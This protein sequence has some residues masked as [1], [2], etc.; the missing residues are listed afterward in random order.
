ML[1][2]RTRCEDRTPLP[3][4]PTEAARL[5]LHP[6]VAGAVPWVARTLEACVRPGARGCSPR[7]VQACGGVRTI[8]SLEFGRCVD[9]GMSFSSGVSIEML[10]AVLASLSSCRD[11][12][13]TRN[14]ETVDEFR[15]LCRLPALGESCV[16][17]RN[18]YPASRT[19]VNTEHYRSS[20]ESER[21]LLCAQ[22]GV[23]E[24]AAHAARQAA[25]V[26][27]QSA[28]L[29]HAADDAATPRHPHGDDGRESRQRRAHE[30]A[31]AVSVSARAAAAATAPNATTGSHVPAVPGAT[32]NAAAASSGSSSR[33]GRGSSVGG[34]PGSL[35]DRTVGDSSASAHVGVS[36]RR[37]RELR[38]AAS[39]TVTAA[40]LARTSETAISEPGPFDVRVRVE[41]EVPVPTSALRD[42]MEPARSDLQLMRTFR[43]GH[44]TSVT[45]PAWQYEVL[46]VWVAR[47]VTQAERL[48]REKPP[49]CV[50]RLKLL[51]AAELLLSGARTVTQLATS[52]LAKALQLQDTLYAATHRSRVSPCLSGPAALG[53]PRFAA[54]TPFTV[55]SGTPAAAA[56][57]PHTYAARHG[58]Y[59]TC[60]PVQSRCTSASA[61]GEERA[62]CGD[63]VRPASA[64][65]EGRPGTTSGTDADTFGDKPVIVGLDLESDHASQVT[66]LVLPST[67]LHPGETV[68]VASEEAYDRVPVPRKSLLRVDRSA[69]SDL[70]DLRCPS[71]K[72]ASTSTPPSG[73][74][75]R[76]VGSCQAIAMSDPADLASGMTRLPP[77]LDLT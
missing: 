39:A 66:P 11:W 13:E 29:Q 61:A 43:I 68:I 4:T 10:G 18:T 47:G 44:A 19:H 75:P 71:S 49:R 33:G 48:Q 60:T 40:L 46:L 9:A 7:V 34:P 74:V 2:R 23:G 3:L 31:D 32:A 21:L 15:L 28:L 63:R 6:R 41:R 58:S 70:A 54:G 65:Q 55:R 53:T 1:N 57:T 38:A 26:Y 51:N 45:A 52:M 59:S 64:A 20:I 36:A 25:N 76:R 30:A 72:D 24:S 27:A 77:T 5:R 22:P 8:A 73:R 69:S 50:V 67:P 42:L 56:C 12:H 62:E 16:V 35:A 37:A 14:W 17:M